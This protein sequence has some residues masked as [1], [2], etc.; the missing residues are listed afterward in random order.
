MATDTR[1][2]TLEQQHAFG[3][4]G[5]VVIRH[6]ASPETC[7]GLRDVIQ[8]ELERPVGPIEYEADL[9]YPGAPADRDAS[10]LAGV[11]AVLVQDLLTDRKHR[12]R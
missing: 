12:L 3:R 1:K 11:G 7:A 8:G 9:G 6:L 4:D 5:F 10:G 2:L